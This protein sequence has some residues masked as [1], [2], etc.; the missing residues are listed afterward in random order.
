MTTL[1]VRAGDG[2]GLHVQRS[3]AGGTPVVFLHE[4][5]GDARSW[6]PQVRKLGLRHHCVA[7]N[8]RGYPPSDVPAEVGSYGQARA[9][10][11]LVAVL[12]GLGI[13]SAHLVGLSMGGFAA[14]HAA[15]DHP[16]RCRSIVVAGVGYGAQPEHRALF[17]REAEA[18]AAMFLDD[19]ARAAERYAA[20]PTRVQLLRRNPRAFAE[21]RAGL[22]EHSALGSANTMRAVQA[23]RSSLYDLRERLAEVRVPTLLVVGDED[24]G[25]LET[26]LMLKLTMPAAGLA[27]MPRTG[28]TCNLED[29]DAFTALV[30]DFLA[31]VETGA[32]DLRDPRSVNRGLVGMGADGDG[33]TR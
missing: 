4:F 5:A 18:T 20:G 32:W 19:H 17:A 21:L 15:L 7:Y 24:D 1:T 28:H 27:V 8:A 9:V 23:R 33:P 30:S 14:L 3:G 6:E 26:N 31:T 10:D 12:D 29:A 13:D 2:V 16:D 25:C 22:I 11:D